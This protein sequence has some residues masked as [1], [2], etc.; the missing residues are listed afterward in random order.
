MSRSCSLEEQL[1][2]GLD[3]YVTQ[4]FWDLSLVGTFD[5][6]SLALAYLYHGLDVWTRGSSES[7]WQFLCP[8]EVWAYEYRIYPGGP[9]SDTL[10]EPRRIPRYLVHRLHTNSIAEDPH[11]WRRYLNDRAL[12]DGYWLNRYYLGE[13]VLE[14]RT[15]TSQ[16]RVP[17]FPPCH[18]CTLDG[19]TPEDRLLEYGGFPVD[20]YLVPGDYA[21]YLSTRLQTRLPD[22]RKRH[23]TPAFYEAQAKVGTPTGPTGVVLGDVPFPPGMQVTLDPTLGLGPTLAIP[24]D[25]RQAPPQLQLDLEHATHVPTQ[26]YQELYQR[27]CLA[28]TYIARLYP[29]RHEMAHQAAAVSRLQMENDRLRTRLEGEGIPLDFSNEEEDDDDDSSSD[30]APPPPP[31]SVRQA[32]AGPCRSRR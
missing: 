10:A 24:A 31:S 7:N 4:L 1:R 27:F 5:W 19:M 32:A 14:I 12:T 6:A 11:H 15:A 22:D 20:D 23:R 29:N 16:R 25:L 21:S 13:R 28:R 9:E 17:I 3:S 2:D 26:R 18:M 8:L 30:D